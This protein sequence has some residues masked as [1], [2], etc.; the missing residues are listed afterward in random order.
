MWKR[1][2][3][4]KRIIALDDMPGWDKTTAIPF[5]N[6]TSVPASV[7]FAMQ[8]KML[9]ITTSAASRANIAVFDM[10]GQKVATLI[11]GYIPAG[12]TQFNLHGIAN[13]NYIVRA[14][15]GSSSYAKRISLR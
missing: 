5:A 12:S 11:Q 3:D 1:N 4:D 8:G 13:G 9:A 6:R 7:N 15:I 14:K 2:L 10:L